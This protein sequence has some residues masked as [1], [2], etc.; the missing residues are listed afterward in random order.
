MFKKIE[1]LA[2]KPS[3]YVLLALGGIVAL[4]FAPVRRF[5]APFAARVPG[6]SA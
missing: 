3:T 1:T 4:A 5:L 6:A 2:W